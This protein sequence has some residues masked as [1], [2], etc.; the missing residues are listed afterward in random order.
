M[1]DEAEAEHRR[2]V[3]WIDSL[4]D[5]ELHHVE[6]QSKA[7]RSGRNLRTELTGYV[8]RVRETGS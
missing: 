3:A 6:Q 5:D 1:H 7:S 4:T 8:A 2:A